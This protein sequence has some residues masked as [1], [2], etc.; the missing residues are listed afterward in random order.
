MNEATLAK[1]NERKK[2]E[3]EKHRTTGVRNFIINV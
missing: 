1:I 3:K 2:K